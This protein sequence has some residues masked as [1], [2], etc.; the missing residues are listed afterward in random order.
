M[1]AKIRNTIYMLAVVAGT[2]A[3]TV[4]HS[5]CAGSKVP[6]SQTYDTL[7]LNPAGNGPLIELYFVKGKSHNHPLMAVWIEDTSGKYIQTLYVAESIAKGRFGHGD[8]TQGKW[9]PG[10]LRRPAALP[11]WSHSRGVIESDSLY[12][13]TPDTPIADAYTGATPSGNF[14]LMTNT[15]NALPESY[16]VKFE[17][18]Q[19][20]DWNK[21]WT[22]NKYPG[23]EEYKTS[24]QPSLVYSALVTAQN[25][26]EEIPLSLIGHGHYN[27]SNGT[28]YPD[29]ST[30]TTAKNITDR[31]AIRVID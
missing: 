12:I 1:E 22:N 24:C 18:N 6:L 13:P 29:I 7:R 30:I 3:I 25:R 21:Y 14:L 11:V 5:A 20:W 26:N 10:T 4:I 15:D 16:V 8:N 27:G 28:I 19:T 17:I 2:F 9:M 31:V 23:D